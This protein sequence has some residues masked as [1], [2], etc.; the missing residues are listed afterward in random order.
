MTAM[1]LGEKKNFFFYC[2][3]RARI[4]FHLF[5]CT[6]KHMLL[7]I[8]YCYVMRFLSFSKFGFRL[9]RVSAIIIETAAVAAAA[10][11]DNRCQIYGKLSSINVS[12]CPP[13]PICP[14][15]HYAFSFS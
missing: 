10:A 3:L 6:Q 1:Y 11:I 13:S 14:R 7:V 9:A 15:P 12:M 2:Y 4:Y 5:I 8:L